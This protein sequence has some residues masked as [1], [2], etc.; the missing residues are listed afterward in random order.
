MTI[1]VAAI[2]LIV[3]ASVYVAKHADTGSES[4][5]ACT[6]EARLCPDGSYVG[7]SGPDCAFAAC[8][9]VA[10][11]AVAKL[12]QTILDNGVYITP[13]AVLEDSRCAEDVTCVW[14]G[15]V[16]LQATVRMKDDTTPQNQE[17]TVTSGK[18]FVF[19]NVTIELVRVS[20]ARNSK[21]GIANG[22]Y[23][24]EFSVR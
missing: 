10:E 23:V 15:Q 13:Q 2:V 9:S 17:V 4:P 3:C 1:L 21:S 24:F 6:M 14:A 11:G 22:D 16:R 8:P 7:R 20:P 5:V 12:G 18:P 19:K